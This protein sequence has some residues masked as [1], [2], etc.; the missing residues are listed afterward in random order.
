MTSPGAY[1]MEI[2]VDPDYRG[3]GVA[4][5]LKLLSFRYARNE[6]IAKHTPTT[7]PPTHPFCA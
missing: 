5:A 1:M 2:F 3:R 6:G 7:T 4:M